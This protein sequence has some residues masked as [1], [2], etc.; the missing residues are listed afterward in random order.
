MLLS[1]ALALVTVIIFLFYHRLP[2]ASF[3]V[4]HLLVFVAIVTTFTLLAIQS[5]RTT[6]VPET[7]A[8][9][10]PKKV[11]G[12]RNLIILGVFAIFVALVTT[13]FSLWVYRQND[14]YLDRSR[15]GFISEGEKSEETTEETA[16]EKTNE[17]DEMMTAEEFFKE[18]DDAAAA[19]SEENAEEKADEC[20]VSEGDVPKMS[21]E[22]F[23]DIDEAE[24]D[25]D[26]EKKEEDVS[27]SEEDQE[28]EEET[29]SDD[30]AASDETKK[31]DEEE[32]MKAEEFFKEAE[33][34]K[35]GKDPCECPVDE[36]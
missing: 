1:V 29:T 21:A 10:E 36:A 35:C 20:D 12:G 24:K 33:C 22:E 5:F 13:S 30:A 27:E 25:E 19:S 14:I 11:N 3:S 28:K 8:A 7:P 15:P 23:F 31:V 4:F 18:A 26:A 32:L 16:E 17:A 2:L 9:E 6:P 34:P